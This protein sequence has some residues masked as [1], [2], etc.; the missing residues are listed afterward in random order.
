MTAKAVHAYVCLTLHEEVGHIGEGKE[1]MWDSQPE[2]TPLGMG[3]L[4]VGNGRFPPKDF[5]FVVGKWTNPSVS[6][7]GL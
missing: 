2:L 1:A 6:P 4:L 5:L 7:L 3:H